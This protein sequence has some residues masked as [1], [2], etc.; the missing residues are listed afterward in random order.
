[1]GSRQSG[2]GREE[3]LGGE[4]VVGRNRYLSQAAAL[5]ALNPHPSA[6]REGGTEKG[7]P[8]TD[9]SQRMLAGKVALD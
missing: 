6:P 2:L 3:A 5:T 9:L 7:S 8:Y 1:M 4:M